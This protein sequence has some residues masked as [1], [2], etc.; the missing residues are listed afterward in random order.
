MT[1]ESCWSACWAT[2]LVRVCSY[3]RV[4]QKAEAEAETE[5]E[6]EAEAEAEL[7]RA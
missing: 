5:A 2:S 7:G 3:A 6:T 1:V 4:T